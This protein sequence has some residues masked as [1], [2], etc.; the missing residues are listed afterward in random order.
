[1]SRLLISTRFPTFFSAL[2]LIGAVLFAVG[3][4]TRVNESPTEIVELRAERSILSVGGDPADW[5]IEGSCIG[6]GTC[7]ATAYSARFPTVELARS[8]YT[9]RDSRAFPK[10][11]DSILE[12]AEAA[13]VGKCFDR[14]STPAQLRKCLATS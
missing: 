1:M 6:M 12:A 14:T 7:H 9:V 4:D 2:P 10:T 8:S 11:P 3:C 5:L 13:V